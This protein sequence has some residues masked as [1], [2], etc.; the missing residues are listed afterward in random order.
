MTLPPG[1]VW[2][3]EEERPVYALYTARET[4]DALNVHERTIRRWISSGQLSAE[5]EGGGFRINLDDARRVQAG[6]RTARPVS[7]FQYVEWLE[8]ENERLWALLEKAIGA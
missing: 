2:S 5:K 1:F 3:E 4:A 8:R 6:S 7:P